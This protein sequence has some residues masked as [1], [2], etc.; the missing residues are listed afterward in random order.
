MGGRRHVERR[1]ARL[2]AGGRPAAVMGSHRLQGRYPALSASRG[3]AK[4]STFPG[5]GFL[6]PH[7]GGYSGLF[8]DAVS[9][10]RRIRSTVLDRL[11]LLYLSMCFLAGFITQTRA[12]AHVRSITARRQLRWIAWGTGLGVTPFAVGYAIPYAFG[13]DPSLPMQ[14]SAVPLGLI[15]L[16]YAS[17]IGGGRAN[18][19]CERQASLLGDRQ[20]IHVAA[21][22]PGG[23]FAVGEHGDYSQS[24]DVAA[25]L[26]PEI[27]RAHV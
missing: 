12:L 4:Y 16:S 5:V 14:L 2:G 22:Q 20:R 24:A 7:E 19:R 26:Q 1:D 15:P 6:A 10:A 13:A 27:G 11:Q 17:A 25:D 18:R 8:G 9:I 3:V 21:D 23:A